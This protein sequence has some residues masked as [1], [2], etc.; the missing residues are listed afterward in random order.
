MKTSDTFYRELLDSLYDGVYFVDRDRRITYWNEG[1]ERITGYTASE[2]MG[3]RCAD[4]ILTHI[5][6]QGSTL[7]INGCCPL[8]YTIED[9]MPR[10]AEVYLLHKDGHRVPISVRVAPLRDSNKAIV[11]AVEVFTDNSS[12][13]AALERLKEFEKMAYIDALT[14]L[15]N[16]RYTEIA[17]NARYEELQR[18]GW[19]F[20]V[21]FIDID[22]FKEINDR[23]GHETGDA[24]LAMV[25]KNL[26][27]SVRS[28]DVVGRWGGEE[29]V[30]VVANV[31]HEELRA[32]ANRIRVLIE[33]STLPGDPPL[34]VT[35]SLGAT[36]ARPED[37]VAGIISRADRLMYESK[38]AGR[39]RVTV[40]A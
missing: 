16:R 26:L 11:G 6:E 2:V 3:T 39:N 22:R 12:K 40:D 34:K 37:T 20:G 7:C 10:T 15:A 14:G 30:A 21:I 24:V 33:Q 9:G 27:S 29:F 28:F 1:A 8:A 5:D 36:L 23:H 4:N 19:P 18:Y 31:D 38:T 35:V 13:T 25:A 32:G 17:L